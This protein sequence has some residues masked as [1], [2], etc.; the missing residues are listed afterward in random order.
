MNKIVYEVCFNK[1]PEG[2]DIM[3]NLSCSKRFP[4][5]DLALKCRDVWK[6]YFGIDSKVYAIKSKEFKIEVEEV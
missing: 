1:Y 2:E 6:E 3:F 5:L 4:N